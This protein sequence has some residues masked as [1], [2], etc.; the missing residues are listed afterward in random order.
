M[1]SRHKSIRLRPADITIAVMT[2]VFVI[3]LICPLFSLFSKAFL[4]SAGEFAG[5]GN[6]IEYFSTPSLSVS[7]TNTLTVSCAA[8]VFGTLLGFLY[9]YGLTRTNIKGKTF[10]R[11][12]A[13]IPIFL[14][15]V[16]HGLGLVYLFGKQGVITGLGWDIGLYGRTGIILS[17]IIY[18]FPQSF[19][20]V[21][22]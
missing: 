8:A 17:E 12:V 13:M 4:D 10:F 18:T 5:L 6:Y 19:L 1:K 21:G 16:V 3:I 7:V 20:K 15:T 11:Y 22:S 14:P 2:L 9:A